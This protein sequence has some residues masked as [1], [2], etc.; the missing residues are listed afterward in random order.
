MKSASEHRRNDFS[1]KTVMVM[2]AL[3]IIAGIVSV[4]FYFT[5]VDK[6]QPKILVNSGKAVGEVS[7]T[8]LPQPET[9][10]SSTGEVGITITKP[11]R[12]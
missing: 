4:I 5:V 11:P 3:V 12:E 8:I 10:D 9:E 2:L 7:L 1:N 6:A